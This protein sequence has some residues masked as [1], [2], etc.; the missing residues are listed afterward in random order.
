M[1]VCEC[2]RDCV[3]V[4]VSYE[5]ECM[6]VRDIVCMCERDSVC[7]SK[8]ACVRCVRSDPRGAQSDPL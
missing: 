4:C 5:R 8:C 7:V 2:K 6:S 3:C 1:R